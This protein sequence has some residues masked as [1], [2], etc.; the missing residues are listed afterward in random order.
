MRAVKHQAIG[1]HVQVKKK[2]GINKGLTGYPVA[3]NYIFNKF[4]VNLNLGL[5]T[6]IDAKHLFYLSVYYQPTNLL[7]LILLT[8]PTASPWTQSPWML[9]DILFVILQPQMTYLVS[10]LQSQMAHLFYLMIQIV[11]SGMFPL[12]TSPQLTMIGEW[13][14]WVCRFLI[15]YHIR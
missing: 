7:K 9:L 12:V 11:K 14:H 4:L 1:K 3:Y 2:G 6:T 10:A 8:G 5:C 13:V 15:M